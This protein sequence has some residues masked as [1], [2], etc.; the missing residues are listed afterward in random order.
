VIGPICFINIVM[1]KKN[2]VCIESMKDELDPDPEYG[3][4]NPYKNLTNPDH[5]HVSRYLRKVESSFSCQGSSCVAAKGP[6][7]L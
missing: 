6:L 3:Y 2:Y 5:G 7:V 1:Y 4:P